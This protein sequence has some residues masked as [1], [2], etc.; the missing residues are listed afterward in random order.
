MQ[1]FTP[2]HPTNNARGHKV[3]LAG[4][5]EMGKAE[6]WQEKAINLIDKQEKLIDSIV[7]ASPKTEY[8]V[9]NPRRGDWDKSWMQMLENPQ[10]F[11]QVTWELDNI[12][13][14]DTI[15]FYFDPSTASPIS[16]MELGYAC[17]A[18]FKSVVVCPDG[19]WR[20]GNVDVM[21]NKFGIRQEDTL[22]EAIKNFENELVRALLDRRIQ[23]GA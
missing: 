9:F 19:F 2:P 21:C 4:S 7:R 23:N 16:L 6:N 1:V 22:E 15:L 8:S 10:F 11:Q 18:G 17:G 3:F 13:K 20:K 12:K 5:I 14:S